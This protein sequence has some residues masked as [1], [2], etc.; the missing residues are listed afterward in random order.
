MSW[1]DKLRQVEPYVAGEQPKINNMIKLNTNENPYGPCKQIKDILKEIDIEKLKLY[2]NSDGEE[3][4]HA[5]ADYH[6]LKDNQVFL[7]NGSDEVLALT[8]LTFF[9]GS[10]PVLFPNISYSFYPVYCDLYQMNY[11][12]IILDQDFKMHVEDFKQP[13]SGIIFP[14]QPVLPVEKSGFGQKISRENTAIAGASFAD[15]LQKASRKVSFSNHAL[16]RLE[17][18]Q[19]DLSQEDLQKLDDAVDKMAQKGARESLIYMNDMA[20]VVS[21]ANR[22]VIT[23]MDGKS[24]RGNIFTNIDSAAILS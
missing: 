6:G 14:G 20:F 24:A 11:K 8:F 13:N 3:L 2:P 1:Q 18:R 16:Q 9:N 10:D 22:T 7:G 5:L 12:E 21:V 23:A 15:I 4:R 19:L 17:S